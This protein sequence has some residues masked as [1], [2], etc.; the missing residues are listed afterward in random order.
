VKHDAHRPHL[1]ARAL[2]DPDCP[3]CQE[4]A[5]AGMDD[6]HLLALIGM[7]RN[8]FDELTDPS[9]VSGRRAA[10]GTE[11]RLVELEVRLAR[12]Q[13]LL[14]AFRYVMR[15]ANGL[16]IASEVRE[17]VSLR[18]W[19]L[20]R[21]IP[22]VHPWM[23]PPTAEGAAEA[24][25]GSGSSSAPTPPEAAPEEPERRSERAPHPSRRPARGWPPFLDLPRE[26]EPGAPAQEEQ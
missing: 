22:G 8:E 17:L 25:A 2:L 9:M 11:A 15:N 12:A 16:S 5:V 18:C 1:Q 6:K 19:P 13:A 26:V 7:T 10:T 3:E 14:W 21:P 24:G 4:R 20:V 23:A